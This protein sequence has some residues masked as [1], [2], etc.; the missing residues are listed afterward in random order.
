MQVNVRYFASLR[1]ALGP[2][3]PVVLPAGST[4]GQLRALLQDRSPAHAERLDRDRA[5]RAALNQQMCDETAVLT[6]GAEVAFF[7][8]VTGG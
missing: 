8:P 5:V 7:P 3:E 6:D 1:E 2:Q 4:V